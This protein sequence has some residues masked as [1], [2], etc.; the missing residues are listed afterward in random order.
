M[1]PSVAVVPLPASVEAVGDPFVLG[2]SVEI[3]V[4][5]DPAAARIGAQLAEYLRP[6]TEAVVVTEPAAI[7]HAIVLSL[8]PDES[9]GAEGY[10]LRAEPDRLLIRAAAPAGLF[11]GV[12]TVRQLV[13]DDALPGVEIRDVPRFRWRGMML[14]V[15]RHFFDVPAV[16]RLIELISLYKINV[17]HL[18]LTDDQGWRLEI[19]SRPK[20]TTVGAATQV[21]G[22]SGGFFTRADYAVIAAHA[23][24]HFVTV[25]PEIDLPGHTNAALIAYPELAC[26]GVDPKPYVGVEVGFSSLCTQRPETSVFVDEVI[27]D[28][29]ALSPGSFV[30]IGGDEALSTPDD[31]YV[32]FIARVG[33]VVTGLGK[34]LVGWQEIVKAPIPPG[35]LVQYWD[36]RKPNQA[37]AA[38]QAGAQL[39]LSPANRMY[40]DMAYDA[41]WPLGTDWAARIEVQD[42][43]D[44]DPATLV[45]GA[46]EADVL[47]VEAVLWTET[48]DTMADV[49]IM[50][51]PR[52]AAAA[53][54]AWTAQDR[55]HWSGFRD[56]LGAQAALW[57]QLRVSYYAS[58][59]VDWRAL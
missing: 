12:Q 34:R 53:E 43:Y 37:T 54:V 39:I 51:F 10:L 4:G 57:K 26:A 32:T 19:E 9:L 52:L 41:E 23:A 31:D 46:Q 27:G 58:P 33:S 2:A 1:P 44:W 48:V 18:H 59:Q 24:R 5:D 7:E 16:C 42:A 21:G 47:G 50:T 30:H 45:P 11:Y 28:V 40:L 36:V 56:R 55:R 38:V 17:L 14:D 3:Q 22:G 8:E 29:A 6:I 49:E 20:L 25:V 15:A 35:T 13:A